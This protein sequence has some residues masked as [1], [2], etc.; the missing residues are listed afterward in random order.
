VHSHSGSVTQISFH[1]DSLHICVFVETETEDV[2][3]KVHLSKKKD[4]KFSL[5]STIRKAIQQLHSEI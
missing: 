5:T 1:C 2:I 3:G 4:F